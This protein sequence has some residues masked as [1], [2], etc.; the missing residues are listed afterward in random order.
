MNTSLKHFTRILGHPGA[1]TRA[2]DQRLTKT[3]KLHQNEVQKLN[4]TIVGMVVICDKG[5]VWL[6]ESNILQDYFLR[7][8]RSVMIREKGEVV[9]EAIHEADLRIIYPI[10]SKLKERIRL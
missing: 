7:P 8:A 9:I 3:L 2:A 10:T 6:T 1:T 5:M 4:K